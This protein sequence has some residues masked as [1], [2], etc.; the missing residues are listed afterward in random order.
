M[1]PPETSGSPRRLAPSAD[2]H[3]VDALVVELR[4]REVSGATIGDHLAVVERHLIET[5]R[6]AED[7]FG[8]PERYAA[9]LAAEGRTRGPDRT[10]ALATVLAVP[11]VALPPAATAAALAGSPLEVTAGVVVLAAL[12]LLVLGWL[13]RR[14]ESAVRL[15]LRRPAG[16][17]LLA[18]VVV[19]LMAGLLVLLADPVLVLAPALVA[20]AGLVALLGAVVLLRR[21]PPDPVSGPGEATGPA[22]RG[23]G[24]ALL[25]PVLAAL[26]C[27]LAWAMEV[28]G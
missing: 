28:L 24:P 15:L 20:G 8:P 7:E 11:G 18:P 2:P 21:S 9:S 19:G 25:L 22:G 17:L 14:G 26:G 12:V 5:G 3:W 13:V 16:A 4:L 27:G 23:A 1:N 6:S 10:G